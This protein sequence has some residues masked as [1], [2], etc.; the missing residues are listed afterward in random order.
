MQCIIEKVIMW[1][2]ALDRFP[3]KDPIFFFQFLKVSTNFYEF[4]KFELISEIFKRI[5]DFENW[6]TC[7]QYLGRIHPMLRTVGLAHGAHAR[8]TTRRAPTWSPRPWAARR[9]A[10]HRLFGRRGVARRAVRASKWQRGRAG[11]GRGVGDSL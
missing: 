8:G 3:L 7:E 6:K 5:N 11:Q 2:S 10:R 9:R 1:S 4:F